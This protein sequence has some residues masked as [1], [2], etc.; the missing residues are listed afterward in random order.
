MP[1]YYLYVPS[2]SEQGTLNLRDLYVAGMSAFSGSSFSDPDSLPEVCILCFER[3]D[4]T[5]PSSSYRQ[6]RCSHI[7]HLPCID[8]WLCNRDASCPLCRERFYHLRGPRI[9]YSQSSLPIT[10]PG[11]TV[12]LRRGQPETHYVR[13]M[14]ESV[15]KWAKKKRREERTADTEEEVHSES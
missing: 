9:M 14:I 10:R 1:H 15:K 7:F 2:P 5:S 4:K 6:L 11:T 3:L 12:G 8:D 13:S